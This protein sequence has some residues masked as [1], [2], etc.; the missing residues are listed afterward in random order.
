MVIRSAEVRD[1]KRVLANL[2]YG[3]SFLCFKTMLKLKQ[4]ITSK[5]IV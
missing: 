3:A 1:H 4:K 5:K 2:F